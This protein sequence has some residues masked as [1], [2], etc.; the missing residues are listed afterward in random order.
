MFEATPDCSKQEQMSQI[1][2]VV[3]CTKAVFVKEY[4]VECVASEK[5][6]GR[7]IA[8]VINN[9]IQHDK[10]DMNDCRGQGYHN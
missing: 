1:V 3:K 5:K 10:L 4:F 7:G 6:T 8:Q 9:K 2:R